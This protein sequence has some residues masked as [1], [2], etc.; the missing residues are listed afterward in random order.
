MIGVYKIINI[1]NN[2]YYIG[3]SK[4][5][6]FRIHKHFLELKGNR[7][8]NKHLQSAYDKYGENNFRYIIL[9]LC[10][11]EDLICK[12][13]FYINSGNWDMMYNK[14]RVAYGG[15]AD[16]LS[17]EFVV[18]DLDGNVIERFYSGTDLARFLGYNTNRFH[19]S[20]ANTESRFLRFYRIVTLDFFENNK[21]V[22]NS[23]K[24]YDEIYC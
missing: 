12:E 17:K 13:Q 9:E 7:H 8:K 20:H 1:V 15:G 16:A 11:I 5:I 4:D 19:Y 24:N 21:D 14:T 3:S 22:I 6:D 10:D 2:K 18:L 23:W